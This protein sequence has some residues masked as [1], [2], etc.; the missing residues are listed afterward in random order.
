MWKGSVKDSCKY[1]LSEYNKIKKD[2]DKKYFYAMYGMIVDY[3]KNPDDN[4]FLDVDSISTEK[5]DQNHLKC[6][7]LL[8]NNKSI[9][10]DVRISDNGKD[11][12][13]S[14]R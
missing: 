3:C 14:I 11:F 12:V 9:T 4:G 1:F 8:R 5:I 7:A 10:Y 6:H 13:V 2:S